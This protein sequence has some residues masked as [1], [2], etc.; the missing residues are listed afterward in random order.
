M[1]C[2]LHQT[3]TWTN[4]NS[5]LVRSSDIHLRAYS[6]EIPQPS[7]TKISCNNTYQKFLKKKS[8]RNQWVNLL[9]YHMESRKKTNVVGKWIELMVPAWNKIFPVKKII[10]SADDICGLVQEKCN[11]SALAM[12]L[13]LCG[14]VQERCNSIANAL[15]LRLSCTNPLM[16]CFL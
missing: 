12:E 2:C 5:S 13:H 10:V 1:A 11:S 3:I 8:L 15:E 9:L 7:I 4:T 14:L 16:C 6:Q